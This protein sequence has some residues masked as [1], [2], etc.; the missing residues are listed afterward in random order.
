MPNRIA[1]DLILDRITRLE[2]Q[3]IEHANALDVKL[4]YVLLA[5]IFLAQMGVSLYGQHLTKY[6][7][8]WVILGGIFLIASGVFVFLGLVLMKFQSENEMTLEADRERCV[9]IFR[10]QYPAANDQVIEANFRWGLINAAKNRMSHNSIVIDDK[11]RYLIISYAT[12]FIG[13]VIYAGLV[14]TLIA[15]RSF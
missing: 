13:A 10:T 14:A 12:C 2:D 11:I 15:L 5:I 9:D 3:Q 1:D 6:Q 4:S 7:A 8:L